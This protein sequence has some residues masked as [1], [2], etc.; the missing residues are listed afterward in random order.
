MRLVIQR[1][2]R[3]SVSVDSQVVGAI[4]NGALVFVGVSRDDTQEDAH[5]LAGKTARIRIFDDAEGLL[6]EPISKVQG[7][8][9]I[10]SQF[11]LYGDCRR[12]NRPSYIDAADPVTGR[13][14]FEDY[15]RALR[16]EGVP[17]ETGRYKADMQIELIND[18]PVTVLLESRG[19]GV[20]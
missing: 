13:K 10:V 9:L 7:S 11:T 1:V 4:G 19:R 16:G 20:S 5:Y 6:N 3:A 12:G 14:G 17:V 8:F 18:G 2:V 15:I